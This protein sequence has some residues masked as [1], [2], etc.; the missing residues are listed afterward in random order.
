MATTAM[1]ARVSCFAERGGTIASTK[2]SLMKAWTSHQEPPAAII[3]HV[4]TNDMGRSSCLALREQLADL[5]TFISCMSNEIKPIWSDM[6]PKAG[7]RHAGD[8]NPEDCQ[9]IDR[10]RKDTNRFV[11]RLSTRYGGS[12][13]TH[14]AITLDKTHLFRD[15]GLHLSNAGC[16]RFMG[17]FHQIFSRFAIPQ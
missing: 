8:L 11:R 1:A 15:D 13:V 5:W 14:P 10:I 4:G 7:L 12:F 16:H 2:A 9:R 3:I 6:L 17:D